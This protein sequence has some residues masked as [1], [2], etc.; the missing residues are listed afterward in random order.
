MVVV[1]FLDIKP[2]SILFENTLSMSVLECVVTRVGLKCKG[3]G[4]LCTLSLKM[5]RYLCFCHTLE[6]L[7]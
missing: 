3:E 2:S 1:I 6:D 4:N 5:L 7:Y